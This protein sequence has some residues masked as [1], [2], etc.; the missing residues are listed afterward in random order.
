M[1]CFAN[2]AT[3][4]KKLKHSSLDICLKTCTVIYIFCSKRKSITLDEYFLIIISE[5][6]INYNVNELHE[7][8]LS[9]FWQWAFFR[10]TVLETIS[11]RDK[12]YGHHRCH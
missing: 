5:G 1:T 9:T 3:V 12:P 2:L 8:Y 6:I 4:Y 11:I 10:I 7:R